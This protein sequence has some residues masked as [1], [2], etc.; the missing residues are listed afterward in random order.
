MDPI[1]LSPE[2]LKFVLGIG[3]EQHR[4]AAKFNRSDSSDSLRDDW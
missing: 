4:G 1:S 3:K 2:D